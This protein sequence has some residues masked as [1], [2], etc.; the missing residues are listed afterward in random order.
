MGDVIS[1]GVK[2]IVLALQRLHADTETNEPA[3][4]RKI[5]RIYGLNYQTLVNWMDGPSEHKKLFDF[6]EKAR[7]D[8]GWKE[9]TAYR[10][11]V[12]G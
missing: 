5:G 7:K 3:S 9:E 10:R 11:S 12:K 1:K 2:E 6:I 4:L 8:L